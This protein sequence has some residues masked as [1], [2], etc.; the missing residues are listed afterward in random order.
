MEAIDACASN[1]GWTGAK[2]DSN[3]NPSLKQYRKWWTSNRAKRRRNRPVGW[4]CCHCV[5][6]CSFVFIRV[7][8]YGWNETVNIGNTLENMAHILSIFLSSLPFP[9][10]FS[11][12][13]IHNWYV[14]TCIRYGLWCCWSSF[15]MLFGLGW[16]LLLEMTRQVVQLSLERP[17][18]S[19]F[20]WRR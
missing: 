18:F 7:R 20:W 17:V 3:A 4:W 8:K 5:G 15:M 11:A 2:F 9:F 6:M 13:L 12:L 19:I 16:R 10:W 14:R 1:Y